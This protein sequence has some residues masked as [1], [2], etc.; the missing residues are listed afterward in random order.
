MNTRFFLFRLCI[1][2]SAPF[3]LSFAMEGTDE[4]LDDAGH[5]IFGKAVPLTFLKSG[6]GPLVRLNDGSLFSIPAEHGK[7]H[8][9]LSKDE[10]V[11]WTD[12]PFLDSAKFEIV[13][14]AVIQTRKGT[15]IVGFT[16]M[17]E[18]SPLNWNDST[19]TCDPNAKIPTYVVQSKDNGKTWSKPHKLHDAWTGFNRA[20]IETKDGHI[21]FSTMIMRNNPP[22]HCVLTY[23]SP[24]D[25]AT[26]TPSNVLDSPSSTGHHSGLTEADIISLNDGRLWMVIRTNWDYFYESFSTDNGLTWSAYAKT[27]IDASAAPCALIRLQSGRIVM[28]WNRLY[29]QGE[30]AIERRAGDKNFAEVPASIQRDELSLMYSDDDGRT[31]SSPM[32]IARNNVRRSGYLSYPYLFE[33]QKGVL[34]I[35]TM[36]GNLR[37]AVYES[38]FFPL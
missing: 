4:K 13:C 14:P 21:V 36:Y 3:F 15:I 2:L 9:S 20:I 19:H 6:S 26:W 24:D 8:F 38:D 23:V 37:I 31:W 27:D 7:V 10:G 30:N 25:G 35:T 18:L 16:N 12:Y 28:V 33:P 17:K 22:R 32:I 34:W 5:R 1:L 11:T 29:H